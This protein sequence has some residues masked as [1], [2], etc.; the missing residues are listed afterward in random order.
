MVYGNCYCDEFNSNNKPR[1]DYHKTFTVKL[2]GKTCQREIYALTEFDQK[3][4]Y[5]YE[6]YVPLD[7]S[8]ITCQN[9]NEVLFYLNGLDYSLT[10]TKYI[11]SAFSIKNLETSI[12]QYYNYFK[13]N[14]KVLEPNQ[15]FNIS[16][17]LTFNSKVA[18]KYH[19][20]FINYGKVFKETSNCGFYIRVCHESC[21]E[22]FDSDIDNDNYQCKKCKTNY[23]FVEGSTK[24][25]TIKQMENTNYYFDS[26][27]KIFKKC[28]LSCRR[29]NEKSI[30]GYHNCTE[31]E[32]SYHYI[33]NEKIQKNCI[34]ESKKPFNSYL[35]TE[36]NTYELC[37][38]RCSSCSQRSDIV[39][40]NCDTCAKDE[41]GN[42]LYHFV[43]N[44]PKQCITE[45]EKPSNTYLN[46]NTNTYKLC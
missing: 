28:H 35:D 44:K 17:Q 12:S 31:C 22:C 6:H 14:N 16:S 39:N 3:I 8:R 34:H 42:Y 15:K 26:T 13:L 20:N 27:E 18:Q 32:E 19:I 25:A 30:E 29:C 40:N 5:D 43:Y 36:T 7:A 9:N 37:H 4:N 33:F 24:C 11:T 1:G 10:L 38:D 41:N 2:G 46:T 21:S 45:K 23:Y